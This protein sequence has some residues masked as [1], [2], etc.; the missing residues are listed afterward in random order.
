MTDIRNM[1]EDPNFPEEDITSEE[2]AFCSMTADDGT[3]AMAKVAVKG[4]VKSAE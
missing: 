3:K 1:P 2:D 4:T